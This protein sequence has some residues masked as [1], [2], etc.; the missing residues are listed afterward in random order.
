MGASGSA[1]D[2]PYQQ[3]QGFFVEIGM[4]VV[5][6]DDLEGSLDGLQ[7]PASP[8]DDRGSGISA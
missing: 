4:R 6:P 8:G 7:S 2:V 5:G 1:S 3:S